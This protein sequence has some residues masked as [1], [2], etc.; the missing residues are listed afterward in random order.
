MKRKFIIGG[1]IVLCLAGLAGIASQVFK[2]K[3]RSR[4]EPSEEDIKKAI[5][6][7]ILKGEELLDVMFSE[8]ALDWDG[9]D[10]EFAEKYYNQRINGTID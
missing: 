8:I 9:E 7:A 1:S 6:E 4:P 3:K 10:R 5:D 2:K